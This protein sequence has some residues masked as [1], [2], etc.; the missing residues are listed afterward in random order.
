MNEVLSLYKTEKEIEPP[1]TETDQAANE[2]NSKRQSQ[3]RS[4]FRIGKSFG[5]SNRIDSV[6]DAIFK[7]QAG[8]PVQKPVPPRKPRADGPAKKVS[9]ENL[10]IHFG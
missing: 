5:S 1:A 3:R 9:T 7:H 10:T 6:G 8:K 2:A 4:P